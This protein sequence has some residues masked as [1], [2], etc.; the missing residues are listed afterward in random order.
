MVVLSI[1]L[2]RWRVEKGLKEMGNDFH[3]QKRTG[4]RTD[5]AQEHPNFIFIA[6]NLKYLRI[7]QDKMPVDS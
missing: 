7:L 3:N 6:M 1:L 4:R 5:V 2:I